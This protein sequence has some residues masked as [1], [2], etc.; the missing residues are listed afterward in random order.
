MTGVGGF[1]EGINNAQCDCPGGFAG[2]YCEL[3]T[4]Q[5]PPACANWQTCRAGV[6]DCVPFLTGA[7]CGQYQCEKFESP[8]TSAFIRSP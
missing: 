4:G 6:C 8:V 3:S 5:C 2:P 1:D 7:T